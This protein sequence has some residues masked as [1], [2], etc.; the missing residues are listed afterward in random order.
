ML[1][2]LFLSVLSLAIAISA[3][4]T[5]IIKVVALDGSISYLGRLANS[6]DSFKSF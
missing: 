5:G 1:F 3:Q 4:T 2:K 6:G